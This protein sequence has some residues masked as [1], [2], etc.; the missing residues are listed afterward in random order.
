MTVRLL[1]AGTRPHARLCGTLTQLRTCFRL[2]P[3][4]GGGCGA[5]AAVSGSWLGSEVAGPSGRPTR[6]LLWAPPD[7]CG[8]TTP[9]AAGPF[10]QAL[11]SVEASSQLSS[12]LWLPSPRHPSLCRWRSPCWSPGGV[13]AKDRPPPAPAPRVVSRCPQPSPPPSLALQG[14]VPPAPPPSSP[15]SPRPPLRCS[16]SLRWCSCGSSGS[17]PSAL[18]RG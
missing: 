9:A 13:G 18:R 14:R 6:S 3:R 17:A 15:C 16:G 8:G 4:S 2:H 7:R 12:L 10:F 5:G 11:P 1:P